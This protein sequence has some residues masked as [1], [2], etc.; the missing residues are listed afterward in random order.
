MTLYQWW[1]LPVASAIGLVA[2][3]AL[4]AAIGAPRPWMRALG[5]VVIA[6]NPVAMCALMLMSRVEVP[7]C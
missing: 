5:V 4:L 2:L 6:L 7:P 3:S 1:A